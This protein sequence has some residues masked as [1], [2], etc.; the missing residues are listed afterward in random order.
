MLQ[1]FGDE[2]HDPKRERVFAVA[3]IFGTEQQWVEFRGPWEDRLQGKAF[4]ATDCETDRGDFAGTDHSENLKLYAELTK[5]LASSHLIGFGSGMDLAGY[6]EFFP[7]RP[8]DIPCY[9]C[10]RDV[11]LQCGKWTKWA[12]PR[13]EA[14]FYF[15]Q[16]VESNYNAAVLYAHLAT[17]SDWDCAPFLRK[18]LTIASRTDV[19][20]QA[21]DLYAREVMK[22]LDNTVGPVMRPTRRSMETLIA[23]KRF[24]CDLH[25]RDFFED[26][27]KKFDSIAESAGM[28][29]DLYREWL[30]KT[31]KADSISSRHRYLIDLEAA[32]SERLT[33]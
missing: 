5:I 1:V 13:D 31:S 6:H 20:I 27:R 24:G 16:R 4:H 10:F 26:F 18:T 8:A 23:T 30:T 33:K 19:G 12:I 3:A 28:S 21:A 7:D 15:D 22:H 14:Q 11:V 9:R 2:S 32:D 17:L 25:L 29:E